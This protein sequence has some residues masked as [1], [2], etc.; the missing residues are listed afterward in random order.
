MNRNEINWWDGQ[1]ATDMWILEIKFVSGTGY[2]KNKDKD[3]IENYYELFWDCPDVVQMTIYDP[4]GNWVV[5]K[6]KFV[7]KEMKKV[8]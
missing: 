4:A 1:P 8:G 2:L 6:S 5:S 7:N 3:K